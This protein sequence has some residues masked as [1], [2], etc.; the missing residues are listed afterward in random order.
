MRRV[1]FHSTFLASPIHLFDR[2]KGVVVLGVANDEGM[3]SF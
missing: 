3:H 2:L 1:W